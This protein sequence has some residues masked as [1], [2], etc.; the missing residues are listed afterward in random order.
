[1]S[2][3]SSAAK[4]VSNV[5]KKP[6]RVF[7]K[8]VP[9][10]QTCC[11]QKLQLFKVFSQFLAFKHL[12]P[13]EV[14]EQVR[15]SISVDLE[16]KSSLI[17]RDPFTHHYFKIFMLD[18]DELIASTESALDFDDLDDSKIFDANCKKLVDLKYVFTELNN[19]YFSTRKF[20][21]EESVQLLDSDE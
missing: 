9:N 14:D 8:P 11:L 7:L 6:R 15:A 20:K 18:P 19:Y 12:C 4:C 21:L 10:F 13:S 17:S 2:N 5:S 16:N 3:S 1:M